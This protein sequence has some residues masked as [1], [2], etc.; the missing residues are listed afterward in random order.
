MSMT[1]KQYNHAL[2][3]QARKEGLYEAL[4]GAWCATIIAGYRLANVSPAKA[5]DYII[6][7]IAYKAPVVV[8]PKHV[9][10]A[11][12]VEAPAREYTLAE[13]LSLWAKAA[14]KRPTQTPADAFP[15]GH[16]YVAVYVSGR[17]TTAKVLKE[18]GFTREGT[19]CYSR[20]FFADGQSADAAYERAA[21]FAKRLEGAFLIHQIEDA[22]VYA[23]TRID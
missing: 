21:F 6:E 5:L 9:A 15:C 18:A 1:R 20:A 2:T 3:A 13:R 12:I 22:S 16:A 10:V 17:S 4:M 11:D 23:G 8:E 14:A 7:G 19:G